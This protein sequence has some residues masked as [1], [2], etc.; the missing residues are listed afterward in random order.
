MANQRGIDKRRPK[1]CDPDTLPVD[2]SQGERQREPMENR[3]EEKAKTNGLSGNTAKILIELRR[4]SKSRRDDSL[5]PVAQRI[6]R[7]QGMIQ[8]LFSDDK[9]G[10]D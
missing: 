7:I 6:S 1:R 9:K 8:N 3:T 2:N 10:G 5:I 4:L